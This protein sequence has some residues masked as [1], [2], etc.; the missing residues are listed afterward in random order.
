MTG[1]FLQDY[2]VRAVH[3]TTTSAISYPPSQA[4][5]FFFFLKKKKKK[6]NV[7]HLSHLYTKNLPKNQPPLIYL[8]IRYTQAIETNMKMKVAL[9]SSLQQT[10]ARDCKNIFSPRLPLSQ[11]LSCGE[12]FELY[13]CPDI[14]K[15]N[16]PRETS[17]HSQK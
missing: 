3:I 14:R 15:I 1:S 11:T 7:M 16:A 13:T 12:I 17:T 6:T 10:I 9:Q 4:F 8:P 5:F 2:Q